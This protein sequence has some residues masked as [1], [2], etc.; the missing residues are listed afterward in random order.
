MINDQKEKINY[1][2]EERTTK[3]GINIIKL[4][5]KIS[6]TPENLPII[7]QLVKAGTSV[8]ANYC[9]ATE[10]ESKKDFIHKIG[11]AKKEAKETKFWL[12]M[13]LIAEPKLKEEIDSLSEETQE[14]IL[15]FSKIKQSCTKLIIDNCKLKIH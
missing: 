15:I 4:A 6:K 11:I 7:S 10:G 9:E 13:T 12:K 14:L 8:G 3:F 2:L 1:N 5:K